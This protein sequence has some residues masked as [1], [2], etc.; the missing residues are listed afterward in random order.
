MKCK[1]GTWK[2]IN[3]RGK[4]VK[5]N[6]LGQPIR[7][8]GTNVDIS[9]RKSFENELIKAKDKA[10]E[11]D[12]LKTAFLCNI[13]HEIRTPMNGI[14][15]FAELLQ[16][17][18]LTDEKKIYY[19]EVINES[20]QQLLSVITDIIDIS[21]IES[22]QM[23]SNRNIVNINSTLASIYDLFILQS[24]QKGIYLQYPITSQFNDLEIFTDETKLKQ[25][26]S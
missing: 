6:T 20:C 15:G 26:I 13:S 8:V 1:N 19:I 18:E 21:K 25:I 9:E 24:Q 16:D 23:Q 22:G 10:E 3:G 7:I 17:P 2:W 14:L 4:V 5:Y 12:K 11:S